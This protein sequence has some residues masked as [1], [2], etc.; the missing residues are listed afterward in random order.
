A[1]QLRPRAL[2]LMNLFRDQLDRH[3]ELEALATRWADALAGL[4]PALT[5]AVVNADDPAVAALAARRPGSITFGIDDSGVAL[6]A[7]P[8][9]ADAKRCRACGGP[10]VHDL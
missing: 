3:G 10:L 9:A 2:V 7:L 6:P 4:P 8:H 5:T 1:A